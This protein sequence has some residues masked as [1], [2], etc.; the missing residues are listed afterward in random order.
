MKLS[1][2][3]LQIGV[4]TLYFIFLL[5]GV[6]GLV[7]E[8]RR[9]KA[10]GGLPAGTLKPW[11]AGVGE[12]FVF[13]GVWLLSFLVLPQINWESVLATFVSGFYANITQAVCTVLVM[14]FLGRP[15]LDK[16]DRIKVK[17]GMMEDENGI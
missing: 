4:W 3:S 9:I 11:A 12:V 14:L 8:W 16:L 6:Y 5:I 10:A 13:L 7:G 1:P 2:E 15:L 17:Y